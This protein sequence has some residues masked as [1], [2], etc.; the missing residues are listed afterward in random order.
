MTWAFAQVRPHVALRGRSCAVWDILAR[1]VSRPGYYRLFL[2]HL[3]IHYCIHVLV[4]IGSMS[5]VISA[6]WWLVLSCSDVQV[7]FLAH[8]HVGRRGLESNRG[9]PF[10]RA[11]GF[12]NITAIPPRVWVV[13]CF[14]FPPAVECWCWRWRAPRPCVLSP[15]FYSLLGRIS[16]LRRVRLGS[17]LGPGNFSSGPKS[18]G[19]RNGGLSLARFGGV[20][21]LNGHMRSITYNIWRRRD[22]RH[23]RA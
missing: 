10:F 20:C 17:P 14:K 12:F 5:P 7:Q 4:F 13:S 15:S 19:E 9:P 6:A 21:P 23:V 3:L 1:G 11:P 16:W 2:N 18:S 22:A 8:T